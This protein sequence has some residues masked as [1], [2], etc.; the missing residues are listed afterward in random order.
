MNADPR[1]AGGRLLLA[2]IIALVAVG[3]LST[4]LYLPSLPAIG[5]DLGADVAGTQ[6]TLSMYMV[7]FALAQLVYGPLSD[8]FGRR[9]VVIGG[10]A[11]YVAATVACAFAATIDQ[12]VAA[13][14]LQA[15]GACAG[16]VLG[17][18]IVRDVYGRDG[19]ARMLALVGSVMAFAPAIGPVLGGIVEVHFG[20]RWNFALLLAFS[21]A[22][23]ALLAWKLVETNRQR[24]AAA[25]DPARMLR[26]Y[27]TLLR[28][29]RYLG[30]ALCVS[31]GY[32]GLFA[33]I[34]G[35]SFV[36]IDDLGL[37]PD[38]YSWFFLMCVVGYFLGAQTAAHLTMRLGVD[39]MLMLGAAVNVAGGTGML[40]AALSGIVTPDVAGAAYLVF[41]MAVF[42]LGMG[43]GMPNGQGGALG[44]YPHMAGSASALMGFIQMSCAALV[45]IA[46]GRLHDGTPTVL[47]CLVLFCALAV[48]ASLAFLVRPFARR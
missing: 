34:S 45:G 27:A 28:D 24:D 4:D 35:S 2:L 47:A 3:P 14:A 30:Y 21:A 29:R 42:V 44:P 43:I 5:R 19:A 15:A 41:P 1:P 11:I 6:L 48:T 8:R 32:G 20:W 31:F 10:I 38:V 40:A 25:L 13:R 23:L 46:F 22:L 16:V 26:N 33:F 39:R 9:P 36:L 37:A 12:L 17:R 18:A 7:A